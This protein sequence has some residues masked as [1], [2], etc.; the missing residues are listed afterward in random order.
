MCKAV[1]I[2]NIESDLILTGKQLIHHPLDKIQYQK[3]YPEAYVFDKIVPMQ[4]L[5]LL[6]IRYDTVIT[7]CSSAA[8]SFSYDINIDWIGTESNPKLLVALGKQELKV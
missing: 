4:L 6:D 8:F 7:I 3:Y 2:T 1:L 5:N